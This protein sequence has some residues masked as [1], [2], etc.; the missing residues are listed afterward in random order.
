MKVR[1]LS[2]EELASWVTPA[3]ALETVTTA[4][5]NEG[6]AANVIITRLRDG[7]MAAGASTVVIADDGEEERL[8][9]V[10]TNKEHWDNL[11][12]N[13]AGHEFWTTAQLELWTE[14][15]SVRITYHGLRIDPEGL[16]EWTGNS[17]SSPAA[18]APA[19]SVTPVPAVRGRLR[20]DFWDDLWVEICRRIYQDGFTPKTQAEIERAMLDWAS[21]N[22]HEIG[23]TAVRAAARKLMV[24]FRD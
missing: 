16:I 22:G 6:M 1:Q 18:A 24:L 13:T 15:D 23:E 12:D 8:S 3:K 10:T 19:F 5:G 7:L 4:L 11:A 21:A 17:R 2:A 9:N 14:R 20:K